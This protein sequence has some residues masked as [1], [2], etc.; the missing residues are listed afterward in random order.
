MLRAMSIDWKQLAL[1]VTGSAGALTYLFLMILVVGHRRRREFERVL[2]FLALAMFLVYSG[3][4]LQ[5]QIDSNAFN[6]PTYAA[7]FAEVLILAGLLFAPGLIWHVHRAYAVSRPDLSQS[8]VGSGFWPAVLVYAPVPVLALFWWILSDRFDLDSA[9]TLVYVWLFLALA[10]FALPTLR[11]ALTN[12][13]F[14]K[15]A[16]SL[17]PAARTEARLHRFLAGNEAALFVCLIAFAPLSSSS[18]ANQALGYA[19]FLLGWLPGAAIVYAIVRYDFFEISV[20]RNLVYAVSAAFLALIYLTIVR[21]VSVW[22]EPVFPPEGTAAILLFTSLIFFEPLQRIANRVLLKR[23]QEQMQKLQSLSGELQ[24]TAR[25][26]NVGK[27]LAFAAGRVR[28]DFQLECVRI[29]LT[30]GDEASAKIQSAIIEGKRPVWAGQPLRME[31]GKKGAEIGHIEATPVGSLISGETRAALE[32]LAEQLPAHIALSRAVEQKLELE[33]E[34]AERERLALVGQMT[35]SISHTLKNPLGSMKT[36]LQ[37]QLENPAL[38]ESTRSD[39]AIVLAELERLNSKVNELLSFARPPVVA[40][41]TQQPVNLSQSVIRTVE[42]LKR[43]AERRSCGIVLADSTTGATVRGTE[44]AL[45]DILA[46]LI[47][48][49]IEISPAGSEIAVQVAA[50]DG[51]VSICVVDDGP[52]IPAEQQARLFQPFFTTKPGGTGLGLATVARRAAEL[53]GTASC[54]SPIANERGA[55]FTVRLPIASG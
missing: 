43:D 49:A 12:W 47:V 17:G 5:I 4:L 38:D 10:A 39:L 36:V 48:N 21:R 35:A 52:G 50:A 16:T 18:T 30:S 31:L 34:L 54:E 14:A 33:R 28:G 22:L 2:F 24:S 1:V 46:N 45:A 6:A 53:G 20:Q 9:P 29:A 19:I 44:E 15:S 25:E 37:V 41:G 40:S 27:F 7:Q 23:T 13:K 3:S 55:K 32:F 42:L 11:G 51:H 8:V 26:G